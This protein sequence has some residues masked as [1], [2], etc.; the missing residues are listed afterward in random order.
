MD[1]MA[2]DFSQLTMLLSDRAVTGVEF[3]FLRFDEI[4]LLVGALPAVANHKKAW[5][6]A[7]KTPQSHSWET[8]GWSVDTVGF[9][10]RKVAFK[11]H[12]I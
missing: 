7:K 9:A 11:R 3:L 2:I 12:D 6:V 5:W 8:A 4:E 10:A 1:S